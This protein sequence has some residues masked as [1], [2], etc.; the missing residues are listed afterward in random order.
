M[1]NDWTE[2]EPINDPERP[3]LDVTSLAVDDA[4][5]ESR[6]CP[7]CDGGGLATIY[8]PDY[9]GSAVMAGMGRP[10]VARTT[11]YCVCAYGRWLMVCHKKN[12]KS[13]FARTPDFA[14]IKGK[15]S[16][17]LERDPTLP[18]IPEP[19]EPMTVRDTFRMLC[20]SWRSRGA[21]RAFERDERQRE[22]ESWLIQFLAHFLRGDPATWEEI[23]DAASRQ[24]RNNLSELRQAGE[25]LR[26]KIDRTTGQEIWSL[27]GA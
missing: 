14:E 25:L 26:V 13:V 6:S 7:H 2:G 12:S 8:H 15:S 16:Y 23:A 9:T 17:W 19:L 27:P 24:G 1:S 20:E 22:R 11:A 4:Q 21:P 5:R 3:G 18:D 10:H